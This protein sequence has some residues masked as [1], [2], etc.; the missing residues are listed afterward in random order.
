VDKKFRHKFTQVGLHSG[1]GTEL[2][3]YSIRT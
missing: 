3:R 2:D 1:F